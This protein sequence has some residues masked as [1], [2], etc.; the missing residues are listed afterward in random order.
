MEGVKKIF[1]GNNNQ[2]KV[3][4][5]IIISVMLV[6]KRDNASLNLGSGKVENGMDSSNIYD[7]GVDH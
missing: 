4:E 3:E 6:S 1:H 5:T 7:T 2:K